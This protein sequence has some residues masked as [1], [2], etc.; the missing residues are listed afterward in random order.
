[1]KPA[2]TYEEQLEILIKR[3]LY[4]DN[5][6][7]A[8]HTLS[9]VNYYNLTGYLFQFKDSKGNFSGGVSFEQG[10]Q[11]PSKNVGFGSLKM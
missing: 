8:V 9:N 6:K 3:G 4:I 11:G 5:N 7:R 10:C 2:K 1:M